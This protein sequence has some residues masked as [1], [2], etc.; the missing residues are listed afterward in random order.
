MTERKTVEVYVCMDADGDY[1]CACD[2][3]TAVSWYNDNIGG[4]GSLRIV[5]LN[6]TM[7]PPPAEVEASVTVP[8][9]AGQTV[10]VTAS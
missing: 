5:K 2:S 10:E 1:E 8:D 4:S 6:V 7:A 9:E 3:D